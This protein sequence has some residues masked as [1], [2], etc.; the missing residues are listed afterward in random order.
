MGGLTNLQS[1][2][3]FD[4]RLWGAI[5][6]EL[7]S[8]AQLQ[9]LDVSDNRLSGEIPPELANLAKLEVLDLFDNNITGAIP[10]G[11][12]SLANLDTVYLDGNDLSGCI[13]ATW[14]SL[15]NE[16]FD[17]LGLPFCDV[18]LS[19]LTIS[20]GQ[21]DPEFDSGTSVYTAEVDQAQLT[22]TPASLQGATF[23][24][25]DGNG[26]DIPDADETLDGHQADLDYGITTIKIKVVSQDGE[27]SHTYTIKVSRL[28]EPDA[29]AIIDPI[30]AGPASL[31]VSW[32]APTETRGGDVSSYDVRYIV[33]AA[34]DKADDNWTMLDGA[35]TTGPLSY[36]IVGLIAGTQYDIQV[37]AATSAGAGPWSTTLT[38]TPNEGECSTEGAVSDATNKP[39]LAADCE[40]LLI[41]RDS[42][43]GAASLDWQA[44]TSIGDWDG[45]Q[46]SGT[47]QR[48]TGLDLEDSQLT[49]TIPSELGS[50]TYL[51]DLSLGDNRLTGP[52]PEEL[53]DLGDLRDLYLDGNQLSGAIPDWLSDLYQ[54]QYLYLNGNQLSGCVPDALRYLNIN[55]DFIAVDANGDGDTDDAGDT[56]GLPFCTL[57]LLA[58][59]TPAFS[60]NLTLNPEFTSSTTTYTASAAHGVTSTTVTA[61]LNNAV[62][63]VSIIKGTDTYT[64][65]ESVPLDL[66]AN[67]ITIEV[68]RPDDPLTPH[69][70]TVTVTVGDVNEPPV[71]TGTV[72]FTYRENGTA[73]LHT[74]KATDPERSAIAW[75]VSGTDEDDFTIGETGVLSFAS[76]PNYE[77]PTDSGSD[78]VYEVTVVAKDDAF[79][80]GTL[81]VTV[82]VTDQNEGP[83]ISGTTSLSFTENQTTEW[84]LATYTATDPEDPSAA[85]T[86]WGLSG[87]DA[88]DFTIDESGQLTFRNVPDHEKPADSGRNNEYNFSVRASDGSLYGYLEVTVTVEDVNEPPAV[89]GTDTF[90]YREN[91]TATLH[92]FKATDPERSAIAWSVSGTD[93]DDFAI[94]E[95][96]VLAFA[97]P[98][99][100]E[101]PT[102]SGSD[103]VYEVTVV[104]KDDAFNSGTLDVTVTV[105]DQNEGPE[106]SGQQSLSFT[107][108]QT[109]ER[110]LVTYTATDPEDPSASI[111]RWSLTGTDAGDFTIS[112][113]GQLTFRNV[114]DHERPA[115]SWQ[116]QRLRPVRAGLRRAELRL[117]GGH[118][119][120][121]GRE[122]GPHYHHHL[123]D[124]LQLPGERYGHHLH[125]QGHRP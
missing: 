66:G 62:N 87:T 64:S 69:I 37:R 17:D 8:L 23:E 48:V 106:I 121:P 16:D 122:R 76:P 33:S 95:T 22:I 39:G 63:T 80:S 70:Y 10:E 4:N 73:T 74:F 12:G 60:G 38:G 40:V 57:G 29:P 91:G 112:E 104:A 96:G 119:H 118:R 105:T 32:T 20:P 83:E 61:S 55:H 71:A 67:V 49:G 116:G 11:L 117:P 78:N 84:V 108:N 27:E 47:P 34:T 19:S 92:T 82:T 53:G 99:N 88:G 103:N 65:G 26:E 97:S 113:N 114:P 25:L 50:L 79:N 43:A 46:V 21:L 120:G 59:S 44:S 98:P 100:Y 2:E 102:D 42:L 107:E 72:T 6:S 68:T 94:S 89:T 30:G 111:T 56:P 115:D 24:F 5:P 77:S 31:T 110:V 15:D 41:A 18:S 86:R 81:D 85:I 125:L 124:G 7:G 36:T 1:L 58:L 75:S 45:V 109:T 9:V 28:G 90:T 54:L 14:R 3:L 13:P 51:Q 52:I 123:Q 101:S 35:W 93:E